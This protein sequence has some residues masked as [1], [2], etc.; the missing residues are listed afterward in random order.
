MIGIGKKWI[1]YRKTNTWQT[2]R[3]KGSF[4]YHPSGYCP[5]SSSLD[6]T[7]TNRTFPSWMPSPSNHEFLILGDGHRK[8]NHVIIMTQG[9][10]WSDDHSNHFQTQT[11]HVVA[12]ISQSFPLPVWMGQKPLNPFCSHP[13]KNGLQKY[14]SPL[15]QLLYPDLLVIYYIILYIPLVLMIE[16]IHTLHYITLHYIT[17]HYITLHYITYILINIYI[18][19]NDIPTHWSNV[20]L[21]FRRVWITR[22]CGTWANAAFCLPWIQWRSCLHH[23][24]PGSVEG[25]NPQNQVGFLYISYGKMDDIHKV[26]DT[27]KMDDTTSYPYFFWNMEK[28]SRS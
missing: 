4:S 6:G 15:I 14:C 17:L 9:F 19:P 12:Y 1:G 8:L 24:S 18:Y 28:C 7:Y 10:P 3:L 20:F 25:I 26:G 2:A 13:N 21:F 27:H 16:Y 5:S 22:S 11:Y 23:G